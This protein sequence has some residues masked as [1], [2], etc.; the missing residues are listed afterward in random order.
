MAE[1]MTVWGTVYSS[2][3]VESGTGFRVDHD[4]TGIYTIW[5]DALFPAT[6]AVVTTQI[7]PNQTDSNGGDGRDNTVVVYTNKASFRVITADNEGKKQN[8]DFAFIA[9]AA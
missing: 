7:Y 2:G 3:A 9:M 6:P 4:Q 5:Y 1:P 8:R